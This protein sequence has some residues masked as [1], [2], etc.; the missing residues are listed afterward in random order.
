MTLMPEWARHLTGTY[1]PEPLQ[2]FWLQPTDRLK[3][4]MVRWAFPEL[5]CKQMALARA[6]GSDVRPLR[7]GGEYAA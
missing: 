1:Q 6:T 7:S 3:G 4:A 5:P 2:R